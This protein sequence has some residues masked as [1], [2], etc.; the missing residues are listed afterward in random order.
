MKRTQQQRVDAK[1][2]I[3]T[4]PSGILD[5]GATSSCSHEDSPF[6]AIGDK[7]N[8]IFQMPTGH[9]TQATEV[10]LLQHKVRDPARQLDIVP[11]IR[12]D[13]LI[14]MAKFAD[15]DYMAV[16]DKDKVEIFDA[17][18]TKVEVTNGAILRR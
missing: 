11:G 15:A 3:G 12:T 7:S 18:N 6:I 5:T 13:S 16:F 9:T 14:S 1:T 17:N 2:N 10:K 4:I 8:K